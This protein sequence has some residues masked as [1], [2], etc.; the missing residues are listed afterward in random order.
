MKRLKHDPKTKI[1]LTAG[2][3]I[4]Q[5]Y[6]LHNWD[7][8]IAGDGSATTWD[9]SAGFGSILY[10]KD[11]TS[12]KFFGGLSN[13]TNNAAEML[14]VL[15]PL[16]YLD[17]F[18]HLDGSPVVY[19]LSDSEYVVNGGNKQ[20]ERKSNLGLWSAVDD[21]SRRFLLIFRHIPRMVLPANVYGDRTGNSIRKLLRD[22]NDEKIYTGTD[23][24]SD[25]G[26]ASDT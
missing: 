16:L 15:H 26:L 11:G 21:I 6:Q 22:F 7:K 19:V 12:K 14:A 4:A 5:T 25:S 1:S 10:S 20:Q 2:E 23:C 17:A 24:G 9:T 3:I 18:P 8:I 13:G